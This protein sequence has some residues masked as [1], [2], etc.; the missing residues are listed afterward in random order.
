MQGTGNVE[1]VEGKAV[2]DAAEHEQQHAGHGRITQAE[3]G[4]AE[5]PGKHGNEHYVLDAELLHGKRNKQ[6]TKRFRCLRN[7]YERIG[8]LYRKGV[9]QGRIGGKGAQEGVGIAVG[10]LQGGA[11]EH[12]EDEEDGK[13][14]VLEQG[15][16][17]ESESLGQG[18]VLLAR[19]DGAGRHGEGVSAEDERKDAGGNELVVAVLHGCSVN[20]EEIGEEHAADE[21]HGAEYPD[22]REFFHRI[23]SF[24]GHGVVRYGINQGDGRHEESYA[25]AVQDEQRSKL[26]GIPGGHAINAGPGHEQ[27]CQAV[28]QGKHLLGFH[29][30]IGQERGHE[31][32]NNALHGK[33]PFDL[34][35]Q[36]DV[37]QIAAQGRKVGAP[38]GKL[39]EQHQD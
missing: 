2:H 1:E 9:G 18:F 15:K 7:G 27:A 38:N 32:G 21:P 20:L 34:R 16:C 11:Q 23:H 25:K 33:E 31:D 29:L 5:Y 36:A 10:N 22:G 39:Q 14:R 30:L 13:L 4:E 17:L 35:T 19:V 26:H 8:V 24:L 28:A 6:D 37:S 12:A 3:E